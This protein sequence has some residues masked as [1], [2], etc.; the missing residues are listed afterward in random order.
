[1]PLIRNNAGASPPVDP[2]ARRA[3]SSGAADERWAAAR[4]LTGPGDVGAL[5]AALEREADARVREAI[6]TSLARIGDTASARAVA[7]YI[8]SDDAGLRTAALDALRAMPGPVADALPD[9]LADPDSDVRV[10]AC[11]LARELA[12][13]QATTL[14]CG[15][16]ERESEPNVVGAAVEVLAEIGGPDALAVLERGAKRWAHEPFLAFSFR[17]ASQRIGADRLG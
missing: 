7:S 14:L 8:R 2:D 4:R 1:M 5:S 16:I 10:L 3:L 12:D 9:L 11:D 15:L 6:F 17:T 13:A